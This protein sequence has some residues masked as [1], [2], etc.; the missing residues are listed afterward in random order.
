MSFRI[1]LFFLFIASTHLNIAQNIDSLYIYEEYE[2][3]INRTI[4]AGELS[5]DQKILVAKAYARLG[6]LDRAT[7]LINNLSL[8]TPT[9]KIEYNNLMGFIALS[10]SQNDQAYTFFERAIQTTGASQ[11]Q[12]ALSHTNIG[13]YYFNTGNNSLMK[14]Y[15]EK[16]LSIYQ[17]IYQESHPSVAGA[18]NNLGLAYSTTNPEKALE[19]YKKALA[20]N[21][22]IYGENHPSLGLSKTNIALIYEL[23]E[24]PREALI[25][26]NE[27]LAIFE[28]AYQN[29]NNKTIAFTRTAIGQA[30]F[31]LQEYSIA[32]KYYQ[33]ALEDYQKEY[34]NKHSDIAHVYNLIGLAYLEK[35]DYEQAVEA[36]NK[37]INQNLQLEDSVYDASIPPIATSNYLNADVLLISLYTMGKVHHQ[38]YTKKSLVRKDIKSALA[39]YEVASD[40]I[41][42]I[43]YARV[44]E[45]DKNK[46][47][48]TAKEIYKDAIKAIYVL[49][50]TSIKGSQYHNKF[51]TFIEKSKAATLLGAISDTKAKKF[52]SI[53]NELL[54]QEKMLAAQITYFEHQYIENPT[55]RVFADSLLVYRREYQQFI[56]DLEK[57][58]EKYYQ[59]KYN[60]ATITVEEL[61]ALLPDSSM[62]VNYFLDKSELYLITVS[63]KKTKVYLLPLDDQFSKNITG[64]RNAIKYKVMP[65]YAETAYQL[66]RVLLPFSFRNKKQLLI[67]PDGQLYTIPFEAL[68]KSNY[69]KNSDYHSFNYLINDVAITY[70]SS[71]TMYKTSLGTQKEETINTAY[72]YAP[73][74]YEYKT[75]NLN[76]LKHAQR[77][78]YLVDSLFTK[79]NIHSTINLKTEASETGIKKL[80]QPA[81]YIHLATHGTVNPKHPQLSKLFLSSDLTN[82][83]FLYNGEVY[84]LNLDAELVTLSACETGLGQIQDGEGVIGLSRSLMYAGAKNIIV[85]YWTVN[86]YSTSQLMFEFY[87]QNLVMKDYAQSLRQAKLT[88]INSTGLK[89]P[90]YWAPFVLIGH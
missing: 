4:S 71:A 44:N 47:G 35:N 56:N 23:Q 27:A 46:L 57:K 28:A 24:K 22:K 26:L 34:K 63:K 83:G 61:Q 81:R 8:S 13:L 60:T 68:L 29:K 51:F 66:G 84:N 41:D 67:F 33:E 74:D 21:S 72:I 30:Y 40:L 7:A 52:S 82:D 90:Y 87:Q 62:A 59:L 80:T 78:A 39:Y 19:N 86:D 20:I 53:P 2:Q 15:M 64:Y 89:E 42:K 10:R 37:A 16:A 9:Q 36:I 50:E 3:V 88:L 73:V 6:E 65:V 25:Y 55:N 58:Y 49:S 18:Y 45:S 17:S 14:E 48:S 70:H 38:R 32:I 76:S 5:V 77:E 1:S 85:S 43:R 31:L 12:E 75:L 69:K 54:T 79:H 11:L